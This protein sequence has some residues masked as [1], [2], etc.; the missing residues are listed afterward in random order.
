MSRSIILG[1]EVD[2]IT[3][4]ETLERIKQFVLSS[5]QHFIVTPN[6]EI[7][8]EAQKDNNYRK[9][10]NKSSLSIPDGV[11]LLYASWI[12]NDPI[13]QRITGTDL[14]Y[15][16]ARIASE[17][18][19]SI[20]FLGGQNNT[21]LKASEELRKLYPQL[22]VAGASE[23][24]N[25]SEFKYDNQELINKINSAKPV[26][27]LVAFGAPKQEKWI[28]YNLEKMPSAKVAIG[29]GGAFN[30]ISGRIKRAPFWM[31]KA[32]LEWLYR[33]LQEPWRIKR[34]FTATFVF[35]AKVIRWRISELM[36]FD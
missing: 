29:V 5:K 19:W 18:S 2:K 22:I 35:L 16:L 28:D 1:V 8:I 14:V 31:R 32:G 20:Y 34:I 4:E 36:N 10:L 6:P 26:I 24:M 33:L 17:N 15:D 7:V 11:G 21:A 13:K 30:F 23:G 25:K 12:F 27:L 3:K 9:L